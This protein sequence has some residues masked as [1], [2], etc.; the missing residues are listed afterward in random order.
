MMGLSFSFQRISSDGKPENYHSGAGLA[1]PDADT[2]AL[3][4]PLM[5]ES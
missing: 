3:Q 1:K 5:E 4:V 2:L